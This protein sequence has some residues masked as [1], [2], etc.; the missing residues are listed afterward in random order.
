MTTTTITG[1][2]GA[3]TFAGA[4]NT[5][6]NQGTITGPVG[7]RADFL[8]NMVVNSGTITSNTSSGLGILVTSRGTVTNQSSGLIS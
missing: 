5:L 2:Q 6:V 7:V 8:D 4:G 3:Y 1:S